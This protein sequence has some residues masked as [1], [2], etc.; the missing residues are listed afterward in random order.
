LVVGNSEPTPLALKKRWE[1]GLGS[2][3]RLKI[4]LG[5]FSLSVLVFITH[6]PTTRLAVALSLLGIAMSTYQRW[7]IYPWKGPNGLAGDI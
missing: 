4:S 2:C 6:A 5:I 3:L 1:T 7:Y